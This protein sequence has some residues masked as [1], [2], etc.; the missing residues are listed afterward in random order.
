MTVTP[1]NMLLL[2]DRVTTLQNHISRLER[3]MQALRSVAREPVGDATPSPPINLASA[4]RRLQ[5]SDDVSA[6]IRPLE[7]PLPA[8][9][10][11]APD[12]P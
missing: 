4:Y 3:Q 9:D 12:S 8:H 2:H 1:H 6:R 5:F 10:S 11:V 7:I